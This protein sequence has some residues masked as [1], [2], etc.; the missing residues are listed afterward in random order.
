M[1]RLNFLP[2]AVD[3]KAR[4]EPLAASQA[5]HRPQPKQV[6]QPVEALAVQR[7]ARPAFATGAQERGRKQIRLLRCAGWFAAQQSAS[8]VPTDACSQSAAA[9]RSSGTPPQGEVPELHAP[10]GGRVETYARPGEYVS[11]TGRTVKIRCAVLPRRCP[12]LAPAQ[13]QRSLAL[14]PSGRYT[15]D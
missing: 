7:I 10:R 15:N 3:R 12:S 9:G 5:A 14:P 8:I 1:A 13:V 2:A 6:H 11:R 4:V